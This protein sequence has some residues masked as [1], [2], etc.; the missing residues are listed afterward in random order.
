MAERAYQGT[1]ERMTQIERLR[2]AIEST[3][4]PK[5][6]AELQ[7][8]IATE[9]AS[10]TSENTRVQLMRLNALA[11]QQLVDSQREELRRR[12]LSSQNTGMPGLD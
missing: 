5:S 3:D 2:E 9:E 6:I 8:R 1:E 12:F 11:E 10:V 7:A 4:D